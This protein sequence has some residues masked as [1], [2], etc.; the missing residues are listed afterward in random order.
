MKRKRIPL[1]RSR[2]KMRKKMRMRKKMIMKRKART[3]RKT[4]KKI[5]ETMNQLTLIQK[6]NAGGN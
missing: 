4:R 5:L 3:K 2:K 6:L 1:K